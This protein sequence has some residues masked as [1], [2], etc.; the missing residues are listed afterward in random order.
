MPS[1][2]EREQVEKTTQVSHDSDQIMDAADPIF[3]P[4]PDECP[5]S[6]F[7]PW[8][9]VSR[10]RGSAWG[11]GGGASRASHVTPRTADGVEGDYTD[12]MPEVLDVGGHPLSMPFATPHIPISPN[13]TTFK[14]PL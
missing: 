8:L 13:I 6:D 4:Y 2:D 7:G 3:V 9:L 11:R 12:D 5:K 10:R 14:I 1:R